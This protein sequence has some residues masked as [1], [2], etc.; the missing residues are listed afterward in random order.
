[1]NGYLIVDVDDLIDGLEERNLALD[2]YDVATSLRNG[3]TL[4]AGLFGAD[5]LV[6]VAF[7]DWSLNRSIPGS[8]HANVQQV[9]V[10]AGYDLFNVPERAFAAD[11]IMVNYFPEGEPVDELILVTTQRDIANIARRVTLSDMGRV[12]LWSDEDLKITGVI[13][14][15]LETILG[16]PTKTVALYIDFENITIGLNDQGYIINLETLI[17][18]MQRQARAHGQVT[19]MQA[20]AP[21]GQRGSLP[22]L[23]DAQGREV[24]DDA[25]S[26]L[27]LANID[28]V[29]N[30]PGKNSADMR[31]AKDVLAASASSNAA[32]VF[33]VASGDRDFNDVFG[34]LRAR[35]KQVVVWGIHGSTSRILEKNPAILLEYVDDF[36]RFQRHTELGEIYDRNIRSDDGEVRVFRPS[37]WSS[38]VLQ[39]D[40]LKALHPRS[41]ISIDD[42]TDQLVDVHTVTSL[43]RAEELVQ[44]AESLG[45]LQIDNVA[46]VTLDESHPIVQKTRLI[47]DRLV[48]RVANTL[49]VRS[50]EYV[51]YGFLLKGISMDTRLAPP[52]M[53]V[54]DNWRS[55]WID[56]L[57]REGLL[58]REL[59]AH[60]HN[61]DDLVP[62]IQLPSDE[63]VTSI[64]SSSAPS[65]VVNERMV[66]EMMTRVTV[67]VEQFTSFRGFEWC[68]LGSLHRRLR[69]YDPG[70]SFQQSVEILMEEGSVNI[71]EYQNPQSSFRTKGISLNT[72]APR[73]EKVLQERD[74]FVR[75]LLELYHGNVPITPEAIARETGKE[76]PW[77]EIWMSIMRLENVINPVPGHEDLFSLFRTHHTV[78]MV[79]DK[80]GYEPEP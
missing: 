58:E 25:P 8:T 21:W 64:P 30:L 77:L 80:Y 51:N 26:R 12:R 65:M 31:I 68:P 72:T 49:S 73:V 55:E 16:I 52:D 44:Q 59:V 5:E 34:A 19:T 40:I 60:R 78:N 79:A 70:M 48:Y 56:A 28:P 50:W 37:Q 1:M 24:S 36:A 32:E 11:A 35:G 10:T 67:S 17:D 66:E 47:R 2:L 53:N 63:E 45:L 29:F 22:P 69:P 27:A 75:G 39:Y 41:N 7:A 3:A 74:D 38:V 33:I 9:F 42:L 15:P 71:Q 54:D 61:P 62:V 6:A 76:E 18:A 46:T 43:A 13:Y 20:Y 14:Q 23:V 57:V 4:A